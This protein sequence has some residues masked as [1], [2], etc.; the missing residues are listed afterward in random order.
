ME[1]YRY[2]SDC[3]TSV[4]IQ[5]PTDPLPGKAILVN[6]YKC[7]HWE[8]FRSGGSLSMVNLE[9]PSSSSTSDNEESDEENYI[10]DASL[11]L[12]D[13]KS[14]HVYYLDARCGGAYTK[15]LGRFS[16]SF[17]AEIYCR[18]LF[19]RHN[20]CAGLFIN[21]ERFHYKVEYDGKKYD[22]HFVIP[23]DHSADSPGAFLIILHYMVD[24]VCAHSLNP[25]D[26]WDQISRS[27]LP[28][29]VR[30]LETVY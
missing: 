7:S 1:T 6:K 20:S 28:P 15:L 13:K 4:R 19:H 11:K 23:S 14:Y 3:G 18:V 17:H 27:P 21:E 9:D 30:K 10:C 8:H 25:Y 24:I 22:D 12:Y 2:P 16:E 29:L 26:N 5:L